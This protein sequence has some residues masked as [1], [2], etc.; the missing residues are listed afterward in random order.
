MVTLGDDNT[1]QKVEVGEKYKELQIIK[2]ENKLEEKKIKFTAIETEIEKLKK[3]NKKN[4]MI[5]E[6][7]KRKVAEA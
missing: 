4:N 3:L 2:E 1:K 6:A 5:M 7:N